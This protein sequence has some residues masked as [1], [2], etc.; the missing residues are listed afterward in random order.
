M[1]RKHLWPYAAMA[2]AMTTVGSTI[3]A[4]KM[5]AQMPIFV[6]M[7]ARFAV[8]SMVLIALLWVLRKPWPR[9]LPASWRLLVAQAFVGSVGYSALLLLGLGLTSAA[10]ASVITGALPALGALLAVF[11]LGERLSPAGWG[12]VALAVLA[13]VLLQTGRGSSGGGDATH[14]G[15]NALVLAAVACEAVFLL[16]NKRLREPIDPLWMAALMSTFSLALCAPFALVQLTLTSGPSFSSS[17][18]WAAVYYALVP[19]TLGFWLWYSGSSQVS[20][21]QA[22]I[23]TALLPVSGLL[24]SAAWFAEPV[25]PRHWFGVGLAVLAIVIGTAMKP[26][27]PAAG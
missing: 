14:L 10:D 9:L 3:V 23:F 22:G 8:A 26:S 18:L 19:T 16:L 11:V 21:A 20:G 4:S 5:M 7:L 2:L 12:A 27:P 25:E 13:M 15:G 6:A 17:A 1:N 24:L